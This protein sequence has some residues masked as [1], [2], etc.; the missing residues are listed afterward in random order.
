MSRKKVIIIGAGPGGLSAGMLLAHHDID[1][2]IYEKNSTIGG[3]NASMRLG[4]FVFDLG[5]TF[6]LMKEVLEDLFHRT[7]R[8]LSDYAELQEID[9]M[10]R[11]HFSDEMVF[12]PTR[13]QD[14][15]KTELERV[16]PGSHDGYLRYLNREK[17][18]Y[19]K[20][21][22]CLAMPYSSL[23][24]MLSWQFISSIPYLD[25]HQS[26]FGVLGRYFDDI[27]LKSSFSFQAKY[28]GMSPWE[29]P[30]LFSILSFIEHGGGIFHVTGGLSQ[31]S[32]AMAKVFEEEGGTIHLSSPV[33]EVLIENGCTVGVRLQDGSEQRADDVVINAD[34][35]HAMTNLVD[36]RHRRKYSNDTIAKKEYSCST[37]MLYLGINKVYDDMEHHSI[38]FA[39]D[40]RANI[41]DI[42]RN[43]VLSEQ[44]SFYVQN[45]S[46]TDPTLAPAGKSTLYVLVPVPNNTSNID[47][48]KEAGPLRDKIIAL[49][50][51]RGGYTDLRSHIEVERVITPQDWQDKADVY[52]GAVFNLGH[53]LKQMLMFR[54]HNEF[55]EFKNCYLVGGG[56]HPG[57][58][59]PTIYQSALISSSLLLKK[60]G[61]QLEIM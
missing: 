7:G 19:E 1:V 43:G 27:H 11:L 3:R 51:T 13:N 32:A 60:Y 59:L 10:Y 20:L 4:D 61:M 58:G 25:L 8:S 14:R 23:K 55:E 21:I 44:P 42:T 24:D 16:F 41:A 15:M 39:D 40:Y 34:F 46:V 5:P 45:A 49:M 57:S 22:P 9:P 33:R 56:T 30:G 37:F 29:A 52:N 26:V 48:S 18:K 31:L 38:I 54:P 35:A 17:K 47:W 6:F 2:H 53:Q 50:E 28:L 36:K 12:Y